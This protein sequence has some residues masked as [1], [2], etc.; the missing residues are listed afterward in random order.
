MSISMTKFFKISVQDTENCSIK[1][2]SN[3][4]T[5]KAKNSNMN[6]KLQTITKSNRNEK[7]FRER[8]GVS[9]VQLLRPSPGWCV[10]LAVLL[11]AV[12][13]TQ[14]CHYKTVDPRHTMCSFR[15]KQC[16]G[17]MLISKSTDNIIV[18]LAN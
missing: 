8:V 16:P 15:S 13:A 11:L 5:R 3:K 2:D 14:G 10:A 18:K 9:P 1:S 12:A 4:C 17:K 6:A 7:T